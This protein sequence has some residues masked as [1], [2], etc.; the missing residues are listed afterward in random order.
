[1]RWNNHLRLDGTHSLL[2]PSKYAWLNYDEDKIDA[3]AYATVAARRGTDLHY[4]AQQMITLGVKLPDTTA[5]L[6]QYVNDAI[7]FRMQ[8]EKILHYSDNCYGQVDAISF[9]KMYL[10][11]HDLKTGVTKCS[12]QQLLIYIALFCLEYGVNP[13][14]IEMEARIYQNDQVEILMAD[15]IEIMVI[16]DKIRTFDLRIKRIREEVYG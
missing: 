6:N 13:N 4:L 14:E 12:M 1:M 7:G 5:T 10:R 3:M 2:S 15:P 8:T 16:M 9:R 11:I